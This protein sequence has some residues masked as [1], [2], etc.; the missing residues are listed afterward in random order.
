MSSWGLPPMFLNLIPESSIMSLNSRCVAMVTVCPSCWSPRP[1]AM[2][3]WTSP[4]EPIV[5][6]VIFRG[7]DAP[8]ANDIGRLLGDARACKAREIPT[9]RMPKRMSDAI[10]A[11]KGR[12]FILE[13]WMLLRHQQLMLAQL[14]SFRSHRFTGTL[15]KTWAAEDRRG[16]SV[17]GK[18]RPLDRRIDPP[19]LL[20][21][22]MRRKSRWL[23]IIE[24]WSHG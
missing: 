5:R 10:F 1:S 17:G 2:K 16:R 19:I 3:G 20:K 4:L 14:V 8:A 13:D 11:G 12:C 9:T 15:R 21:V 22:V 6:H 23:C 24:R 7:R 18:K